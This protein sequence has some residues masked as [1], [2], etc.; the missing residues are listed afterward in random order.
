MPVSCHFQGCK[1]LLRTGKRRYIEYHA[2]A[3]TI[4]A[5][6]TFRD[7]AVVQ[8]AIDLFKY[9]FVVCCRGFTLTKSDIS[10]LSHVSTEQFTEFSVVLAKVAFTVLGLQLQLNQ[11]VVSWSLPVN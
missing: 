8:L 2:F 5:T 1:A 11:L 10:V 9:R 3:V 6:Q 7:P 4:S